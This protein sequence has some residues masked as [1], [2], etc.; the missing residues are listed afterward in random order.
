MST[1]TTTYRSVV[2]LPPS[3]LLLALLQNTPPADVHGLELTDRMSAVQHSV[4]GAVS[5]QPSGHASS[6]AAPIS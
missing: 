5:G 2:G 3:P 6:M 4:L 1:T